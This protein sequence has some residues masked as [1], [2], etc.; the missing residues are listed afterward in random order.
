MDFVDLD[1]KDW[2]LYT[3]L[4]HLQAQQSLKSPSELFAQHIVSIIH[5]I[6]GKCKL[7]T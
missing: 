5:H 4:Q 1:K 2:D 3:V 6:K 7:F